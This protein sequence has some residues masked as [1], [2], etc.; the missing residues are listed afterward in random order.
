[1]DELAKVTGEG[2][3]RLQRVLPGPIERVWAFLTESEKRRTWFAGGEMELRAGGSAELFLFHA[4]LGSVP[5]PT[6]EKFRAVE[7]GLMTHGR[8]VAVEAPRRLTFLWGEGAEESE[9]S[10]E[11]APEGENVRLTLTHRHLKDRA[12][13]RDVSIGWHSHLRVLTDR[14][15]DR[16]PGPFWSQHA[17]IEALYADVA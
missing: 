3:V 9:V 13:M 7:Q 5:E 15:H 17:Q 2:E 4:N 6:P 10:F 16:D 12:E 14:L 11:L 8:I 1:V